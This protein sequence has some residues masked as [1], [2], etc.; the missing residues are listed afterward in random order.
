M[1]TLFCKSDPKYIAI[2]IGLA[3]IFAV[4]LVGISLWLE[5]GVE[6]EVI[7]RMLIALPV[8]IVF[9]LLVRRRS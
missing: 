7:E 6:R 1:K 4:V 5:L 2:L 3:S 8:A 9:F